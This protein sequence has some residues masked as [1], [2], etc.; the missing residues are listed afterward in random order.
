M[1][2]KKTGEPGEARVER[3]VTAPER[4]SV[5]AVVLCDGQYGRIGDLVEVAAGTRSSELDMHPDAVAAA[6]SRKG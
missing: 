4:A 2:I 6:E 1:A 5:R 3:D